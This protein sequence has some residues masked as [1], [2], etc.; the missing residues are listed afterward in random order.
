MC[1]FR[2]ALCLPAY[3]HEKP[4]WAAAVG[5]SPPLYLV[6]PVRYFYWAPGGTRGKPCS[7]APFDSIWCGHAVRRG[8]SEDRPIPIGPIG[9]VA[10]P[11]ESDCVGAWV[12]YST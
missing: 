12:G 5:S 7:V 10:P 2:Y 3:A 4:F 11:A 6:P 9:T 1:H 8:A